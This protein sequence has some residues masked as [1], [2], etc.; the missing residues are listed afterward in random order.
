MNTATHSDICRMYSAQG[1]AKR[2]GRQ[3]GF[4]LVQIAIVVGVI[5]VLMAAAFL[6]VPRV[7]ASVKA[8]ADAQDL[9][10]YALAIQQTPPVQTIDENYFK[11]NDLYPNAKRNTS[12]APT[13]WV[14]RFGG[15][16]AFAGTNGLVGVTSAGVPTLACEK[17]IPIVA[18]TFDSINVGSVPLKEPNKPLVAPSVIHTACVGTSATADSVTI[19][20]K[21][22]R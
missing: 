10:T 4:D 5:G 1:H 3:R 9:Q 6:G 22:F 12:G 20:Y 17:L 16:V 21:L 18:G 14:N 2:S 19:E 8:T 7:M 13:A 11:T 15:V